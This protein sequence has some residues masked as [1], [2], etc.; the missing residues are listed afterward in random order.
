MGAKITKIIRNFNGYEATI[1]PKS[2]CDTMLLNFQPHFGGNGFLA[3]LR[4]MV[5]IES[6]HIYHE[7]N[8]A[9]V[10]T[11]KLSRTKLEKIIFCLKAEKYG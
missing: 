1:Y 9:V 5:R 4:A 6:V 8:M 2:H 10:I 11:Q 7:A 3:M